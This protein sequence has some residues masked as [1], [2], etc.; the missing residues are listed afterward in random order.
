MISFLIR[1]HSRWT[2][3][4][5][6]FAAQK[7]LGFSCCIYFFAFAVP[8]SL[9]PIPYFSVAY[10]LWPLFLLLALLLFL[11]S[12]LPMACCLWPSSS[13]PP[14]VPETR[15][16]TQHGFS[17]MIPETPSAT[18]KDSIRVPCR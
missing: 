9:S 2:V 18:A 1:A 13:T 6:G 5:G 17:L 12:L 3:R 4:R 7:N 15:Q 8:C 16:Q 11:L 14:P 10:C